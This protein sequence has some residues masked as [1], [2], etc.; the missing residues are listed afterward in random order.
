MPGTLG[1][2]I[3]A[4][5]FPLWISKLADGSGSDFSDTSERVVYAPVRAG[6]KV[7]NELASACGDSCPSHILQS[8]LLRRK[9]AR[10]ADPSKAGLSCRYVIRSSSSG[11]NLCLLLQGRSAWGGPVTIWNGIRVLWR[12]PARAHRKLQRV[13]LPNRSIA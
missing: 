13:T 11:T 9:L 4:R 7:I 6:R 3:G 1:M 12:S 2:S 5:S 10:G 8:N